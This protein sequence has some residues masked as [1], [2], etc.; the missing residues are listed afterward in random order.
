MAIGA[1][2]D[3]LDCDLSDLADIYVLTENRL[4]DKGVIDNPII[5]VDD[6]GIPLDDDDD[7]TIPECINRANEFIDYLS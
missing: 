3:A 6:D 5:W 2:I 4:R 7:D 1:V